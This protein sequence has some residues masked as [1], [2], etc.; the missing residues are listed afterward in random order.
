MII[1]QNGGEFKGFAAV[2]NAIS[3]VLLGADGCCAFLLSGTVFF[4]KTHPILACVLQRSTVPDIQTRELRFG[5][6]GSVVGIPDPLL[7]RI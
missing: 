2:S 6:S 4:R 7:R 3:E 5:D 1:P